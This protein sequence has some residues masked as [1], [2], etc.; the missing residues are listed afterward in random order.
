[1]MMM[2]M[3]IVEQSAECKLAGETKVLREHLPQCHIVHHKSHM[4][5][6]GLESEPL[7]WEAGN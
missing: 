5:C 2:M 1:M 4:T 6:P 3:M 7:R